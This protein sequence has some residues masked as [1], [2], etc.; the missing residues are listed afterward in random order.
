MQ[1]SRNKTLA[2]DNKM[3][4]IAVTGID[5][6]NNIISEKILACKLS[7]NMCAKLIP[8]TSLLYPNQS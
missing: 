5:V 6:K 1:I 7:F 8:T 3:S 4:Q 2:N